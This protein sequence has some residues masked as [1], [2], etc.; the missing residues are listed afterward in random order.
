MPQKF[1][2]KPRALAIPLA[3]RT[4]T[5]GACLFTTVALA[6]TEDYY[7]LVTEL[8]KNPQP[9]E[10][11]PTLPSVPEEIR[12]QVVLEISQSPPTL[13]ALKKLNPKGSV[14]DWAAAVAAL[15]N[16]KTVPGL[17]VA[18][19]HHHDVTQL[20]ALRALARLKDPRAV[21][22]LLTY[23][24]YMAVAEAGS[25]SATTH[26]LLQQEIAKT[27]SATTGVEIKLRGGGQDPRGLKKAI[28]TWTQWYL[29][30]A[31]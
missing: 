21:P 25:E 2:T 18:L 24:S 11:Y 14:H 7:T 17:Q 27:L 29:D 5:L 6:E 19:C 15:E 23:A 28:L 13:E 20:A 10:N 3:F 30:Q 1:F 9:Q 8:T 31:K 22:F 26:G 12:M 16:L 4:L